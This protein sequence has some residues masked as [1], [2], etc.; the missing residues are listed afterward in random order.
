MPITKLLVVYLTLTYVLLSHNFCND[1]LCE[2]QNWWLRHFKTLN[3]RQIIIY[4]EH[5]KNTKNVL[6]IQYFR[7]GLNNFFK[8]LNQRDKVL[9]II[10]RMK[11]AKKTIKI[12]SL[13]PW[14]TSIKNFRSRHTH[15]ILEYN[16]L[17]LNFPIW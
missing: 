15:L 5:E 7:R 13:H 9:M 1:H 8:S 6:K 11:S 16:L 17:F 14:H 12:A 2:H 4:N 10:I 3:L